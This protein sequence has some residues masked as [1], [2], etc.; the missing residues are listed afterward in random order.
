MIFL[1]KPKIIYSTDKKSNRIHLLQ[2]QDS[3]VVEVQR[4]KNQLQFKTVSNYYNSQKE[5]AQYFVDL[6]VSYK[7][8]LLYTVTDEN[9]WCPTCERLI[10]KHYKKASTSQI[11]QVMDRYR[12]T[13][14]NK[15]SSLEELIQA[16]EPILKLLPSGTYTVSLRR[17]FPTFGEDRLFSDFED[18]ELTA[19]V[20]YYYQLSK[21]T[22]ESIS[23]TA[24]TVYMLPTQPKE[25]YS[26]DTLRHYRESDYLGRG[27]V[28]GLSGF[29]GCLL[30]G[31]HKAKVAYERKQALECFVIEP[32][33]EDVIYKGIELDGEVLNFHTIPTIEE[34]CYA[35]SFIEDMELTNID[36]LCTLLEQVENNKIN[37]Y[38][39]EMERLLVVMY[40][41]KPDAL[42]ALYD[43][44][45]ETYMYKNLRFTYFR[46]LS[47]LERTKFTEQLMLDFLINDDYENSELTK[48]CEDYFR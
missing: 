47:F 21:N 12:S 38:Y 2:S 20:D 30:D 32:Y 24:S 45:L 25:V 43:V 4:G 29:L 16:N 44:I 3:V 5:N 7:K 11:K 41:F 8:D 40:L 37:D 36:E 6:L 27:I 13:M 14:N 17:I 26:E 46:Y 10:K 42:L 15:T 35:Q 33:I 1:F 22:N 19:S 34:F 9:Y 48:L 18:S 28:V 39:E 31:H 23:S